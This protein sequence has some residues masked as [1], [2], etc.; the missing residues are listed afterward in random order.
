M[1][2]GLFWLY[3]R[4]WAWLDPHP[5]CFNWLT[6]LRSTA[7]IR[8]WIRARPSVVNTSARS[9]SSAGDTNGSRGGSACEG[10]GIERKGEASAQRVGQGPKRSATCLR[11]T[12]LSS[13]R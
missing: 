7:R 4:Q 6:P 2:E 10:G 13:A 5:E 11:S 1:R 3:D 12:K 9:L 8:L